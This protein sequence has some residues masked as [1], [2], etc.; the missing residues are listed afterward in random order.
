MDGDVVHGLLAACE[1]ERVD[2]VVMASH[3]R[4]GLARLLLGSVA[5][6]VLH[7]G[8]PVPV[9]VARGH[10]ED[11][12]ER[13]I[14]R[15]AVALEEGEGNETTVDAALEIA[16]LAGA[17]V[18]LVMA[19]DADRD[20]KATLLPTAV[21]APA[22]DD[23]DVALPDDVPDER[24]Y[25]ARVAHALAAEGVPVD[26]RLVEG[27]RDSADAIARCVAEVRADLVAVGG[28]RGRERGGLADALRHA[29]EVPVLVVPGPA[30]G[31]SA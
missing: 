21:L 18:T 28:G 24:S 26:V 29:V 13:E 25:L 6:R 1:R 11:G 27:G 30:A 15:I 4:G 19:H 23:A 3:A 12:A 2:L 20:R 8:P 16:R 10:A 31:A 14:G 9:L 17:S 5:D 22:A 7:D